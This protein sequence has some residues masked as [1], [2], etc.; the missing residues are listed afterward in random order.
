[1]QAT[2]S[3]IF[4]WVKR[5]VIAAVLVAIGAA[6]VWALLPRPAPVESEKIVSGDSM[7]IRYAAPNR[8]GESTEPPRSLFL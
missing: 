1:M 3:L 6:I 7:D 5:G 2:R 8:L 4:A